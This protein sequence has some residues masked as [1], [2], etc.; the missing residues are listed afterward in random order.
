MWWTI[1]STRRNLAHFQ[2]D[3]K[4]KL[5]ILPYP[6]TPPFTAATKSASGGGSVGGATTPMGC[7]SW[8]DIAVD[9][10]PQ[11]R[12]WKAW[13]KNAMKNQVIQLYYLQMNIH[14][15][16]FCIKHS[17]CKK[18][19]MQIEWNILYVRKWTQMQS[20]C[21]ST[22]LFVDHGC[23]FQSSCF[24]LSSWLVTNS[25]IIIH[26]GRSFPFTDDRK[27]TYLFQSYVTG[28]R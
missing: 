26:Q 20:F 6:T 18:R 8:E 3:G 4:E 28:W 9:K 17:V 5:N 22:H 19:L 21:F 13:L 7:A 10:E 11:G 2:I 12:F 25:L 15:Y 16:R 14:T 23:W 1:Y 24:G 27:T